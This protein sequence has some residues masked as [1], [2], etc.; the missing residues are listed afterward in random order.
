MCYSVSVKEGTLVAENEFGQNSL[1]RFFF[2][3]FFGK[4]EMRTSEW[5]CFSLGVTN[6]EGSS[7]DFKGT[8]SSRTI[9]LPA[10][11]PAKQ[12]CK[13]EKCEIKD[14]KYRGKNKRLS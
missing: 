6:C 12:N 2:F 8:P 3:F 7:N 1:D 10:C 11:P 9:P 5:K 4:S 14:P 13:V